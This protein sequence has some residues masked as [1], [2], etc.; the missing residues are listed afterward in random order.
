[1]PENKNSLDPKKEDDIESLDFDDE[2]ELKI[3]DGNID[4]KIDPSNAKMEGDLTPT[5]NGDVSPSEVNNQG[6]NTS[7]GS[8]DASQNASDTPSNLDNN[9]ST[10]ENMPPSPTSQEQNEASSGDQAPSSNA[11]PSTSE[12]GEDEN[13]PLSNDESNQN[14]EA[15]EGKN[16]KDNKSDEEKV[17]QDK[18]K[19][20]NKGNKDNKENQ[21]NQNNQ[22]KNDNNPRNNENDNLNNKNGQDHNNKNNQDNPK[23]NQN[24]NKNNRHDEGKNQGD[25]SLSNNKEKPKNGL[26]KKRED[27]KNKWNNRPRTPKE[28]AQRAGNNLKNRASN[29]FNNSKAGKAINNAKKVAEKAKKTTKK[30]KDAKKTATVIKVLLASKVFI[31]ILIALVIFCAIIFAVSFFVSG[32]PGVGG[33][34]EDEENYSKYSEVDQATIEKLKSIYESYPDGDPALAMVTA[35]YPYMEELHGGNVNSLKAN[36]NSDDY[37]D[38]EDSEDQAL[39]SDD[40]EDTKDNEND[41]EED[42]PYL[43]LLRSWSFRT[44]KFKKLLK[45]TTDGEESYNNNLKEKYFT[46]DKGYKAMFDGCE[47][48]DALADAIIKDLYD[49]KDDFEGYF[50]EVCITNTSYE[51]VGQVEVNSEAY[52]QMMLGN[53]I[54]EL[55]EPGCGNTNSCSTYTTLSLEDYVKGVVYEEI[56]ARINMENIEQVK[57]QMVAVKSY[58]LSRRTPEQTTDGTYVIK[59]RWSTADQDYCNYETGCEDVQEDHGYNNVGDCLNED[60]SDR[61]KHFWNHGPASQDVI[62]VLDQAWQETQNYYVLDSN[63]IPRGS[64]MA[65]CS[66]GTCMS[67]NDLDTVDGDYI[68]ILTYFYSDYVVAQQ[69]GEYTSAYVGSTTELC[70]DDVSGGI[71]DSE[72]KFYYQTD[73]PDVA[74]CGLDSVAG[75]S[76]TGK[77]TICTSGCGV[78]SYAMVVATLSDTES[79]FDPIAANDEATASGTCSSNG[80]SNGLFTNIANNHS[81]FTIEQLP[82]TKEGANQVLSVLQNGGVVVANVQEPSPFTDGGHWIVIR[83]IT[84]DGSIKVA[85]PNSQSISTSE[86]YD[87]NDF[88]D[89]NWLVDKNGTTHSWFAIYGPRSEEF[90]YVAEAGVATGTLGYPVEGVTGC[91]ASDYP[92]YSDG[93]YHGGTDINSGVGASEGMNILAADGGTVK[94]VKN[95]NYSYGSHVIIDHGNGYTT[96][97]AHMQNG[98]ITVKEG[99]LVS[100]G[101]IIGKLGSTGNST[102]P[103]LH[104]ELRIN[105]KHNNTLNPCEYIG[106]N[107]SYVGN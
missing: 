1:M 15:Q 22:N 4:L 59:M 52:K 18:D 42:D 45:W 6:D 25:N 12:G 38:E 72:F 87:I 78:T 47:D 19:E 69:E 44:F 50:F 102:G 107:K 55:L 94:T 61:C 101:Q 64:Y 73:Y 51:S 26:D 28:A 27:L 86:A 76:G 57:A 66:I 84:S 63:G 36:N 77:N 88:I 30:I 24:G 105:N 8:G 9:S 17:N 97:Y 49:L 82:V 70:G 20:N 29:A 89:K 40:T 31:A 75:C 33:D 48:E 23:D 32:S 106:Q 95:L 7:I 62:S 81:G 83:G 91:D 16:N 53:V 34:V 60:G 74:F 39:V 90:K 99:D 11:A 56:N 65:S 93:D 100:K 103:H 43:E 41:A 2:I 67:Q 13:Q 54:I 80:T 14:K 71:P 92:Y 58:T 68:A 46:K 96:L 85:D 79:T 10:N 3:D 5:S 98:S 35:I 21:N 37:E 104:I